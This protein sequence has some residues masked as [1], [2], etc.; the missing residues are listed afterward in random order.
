[1]PGISGCDSFPFMRL[2]RRLSDNFFMLMIPI[3]CMAVT[4]Y[5]GYSGIF[6]ERGILSLN[7]TRDALA[8]ARQDLDS[9]RGERKALEHRIKLLDEKAI[10]PD[11]LEEVARGILLENGPGEVAI[12]REKH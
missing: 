12:P 5:F 6:G 1:L 2:R 3:I 10:D 11:L 9:V 8:V 4:F 7:E